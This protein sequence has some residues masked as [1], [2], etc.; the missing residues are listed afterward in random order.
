MRKVIETEYRVTSREETV[1]VKC[2]NCGREAEVPD[3]NLP[4]EWGA[5]GGSVGSITRASY[6]DGDYW[7]VRLD[8]CYECAEMIM[9]K[10]GAGEFS[11]VE[12][13]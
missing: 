3:D 9:G 8:L 5:V 2:D 6:I 13:F 1:L 11:K 10:I 7:K 4:F 12:H